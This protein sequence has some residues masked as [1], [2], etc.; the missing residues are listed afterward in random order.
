[1]TPQQFKERWESD[2]TGGGITFEDIEECARDWGLG[3]C[4]SILPTDAIRY[5]VLKAA[6][7]NDAEDYR[8]NTFSKRTDRNT[9]KGQQ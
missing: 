1:M 9:K 2:S 5:L 4:Q 7:V 8:P 3:N 6:H